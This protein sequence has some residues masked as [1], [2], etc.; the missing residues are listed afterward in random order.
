M[1][2]SAVMLAQ[3]YQSEPIAYSLWQLTLIS[4]VD[5]GVPTCIDFLASD[6]NHM[7]AAYSS[8]NVYVFDLSTGQQ[9]VKFN[10]QLPGEK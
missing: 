4:V 5:D 3:H 9:V 1:Y 6:P 7:M 8:G 2:L 10:T